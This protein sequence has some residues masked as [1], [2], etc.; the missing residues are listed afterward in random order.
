MSGSIQGTVINRLNNQ[1]I[2]G[3]N[4]RCQGEGVEREVDTGNDGKYDIGDLGAGEYEMVIH[5]DGFEDGIYG[6]LIVIDGHATEINAGL[7]PK[8]M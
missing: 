8:Q 3:A 1:P 7:D 6:P 2:A 5:K 4:C